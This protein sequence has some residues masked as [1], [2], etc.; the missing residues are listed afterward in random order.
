MKVIDIETIPQP[1]IMNTWYKD[2]A[3]KKFP[4]M[5]DEQL[6]KQAALYPE[7]G[8]ICAI[9]ISDP[10]GKP[11][12]CL[13]GDYYEE[14]NMLVELRGI[15]GET[16]TLIGHNL[17]GF[18]L[19]YLSKR[20]L[21]HDLELPKTLRVAGKK[22]WEIP[23]ID[24]MELL[25]FGG[26]MSMSLRS[27]CFLLGLKD[28]KQEVSGEDVYELFKKKDL[29]LIGAYVEKDVEATGKIFRKLKNLAF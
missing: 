22:P 15:L 16:E 9:G 14:K 21:F 25:K 24:T 3:K 29:D 20:Y 5:T 10:G 6:E 11:T 12:H 4:E 27:A 28:P 17:K 8:M 19:P 18:D 13:A 23:H 2:W 7:F 26:G 1:G